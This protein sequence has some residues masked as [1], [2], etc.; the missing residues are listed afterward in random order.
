MIVDNRVFGGCFAN[1]MSF[2][3]Q[4]ERI[5]RVD[6]DLIEFDDKKVKCGPK[7]CTPRRSVL[8]DFYS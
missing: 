8:E 2:L 5:A 1:F 7:A 4:S 6:A 3:I